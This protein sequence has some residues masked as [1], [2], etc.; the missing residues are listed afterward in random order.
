MISAYKSRML[1]R[2][3]KENDKRVLSYKTAQLT[4]VLQILQEELP[5]SAYQGILERVIQ[6]QESVL[7]NEETSPSESA[8]WASFNL[9][10]DIKPLSYQNFHIGH[11]ELISQKFPHLNQSR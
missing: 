4:S 5:A 1:K 3:E 9:L 2:S 6:P 7:D 11:F 8:Q 10:L